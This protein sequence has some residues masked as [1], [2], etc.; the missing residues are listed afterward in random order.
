ML[1]TGIKHI[2]YSNEMSDVGKSLLDGAKKI[3]RVDIMGFVN[4]LINYIV[5]PAAFV[6]LLI[7]MLVLIAQMGINKKMNNGED[8]GEKSKNLAISFFVWAAI[9][10]YALLF[11]DLMA[12]IIK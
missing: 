9:G 12:T 10:G 6:I 5:V 3:F 8:L 4:G 1:N 7:Y 11:T 2:S